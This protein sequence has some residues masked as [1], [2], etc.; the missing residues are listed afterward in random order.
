M[1]ENRFREISYSVH[2]IA[3]L[4]YFGNVITYSKFPDRGLQ[5]YI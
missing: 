1:G 5:S 3:K 4:G 2:K